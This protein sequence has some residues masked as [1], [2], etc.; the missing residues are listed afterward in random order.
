MPNK[1]IVISYD[2]REK[3]TFWDRLVARSAYEAEARISKLR[4]DYAVVIDCLEASDLLR[5]G[6]QLANTTIPELRAKFTQW[7][8][9]LKRL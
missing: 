4:R 2:A 3:Q 5:I 8:Q 6:T 9:E 1:Y 7:R